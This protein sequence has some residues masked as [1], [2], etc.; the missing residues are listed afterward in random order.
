MPVTDHA[1]AVAF[2][3]TVAV[4]QAQRV[5]TIPGGFAVLNDQYRASYDHNKVILTEAIAPPAALAAVDR[6]LGDA[7][8][9]HRMVHVDDDAH[10][11]WYA[12]AFVAA[13]YSHEINIVMRHTGAAPDRPADQSVN[14]AQVDLDTLRAS[15]RREWR[16]RLPHATSEAI[17]Q[18]VGRRAA[19]LCGADEVTFLAVVDPAGRV[20]SR[21]DLYR[22]GA[23]AQIEDLMTDPVATGRG[24]ARAIMTEA[25]RRTRAA[26]C[27]LTFV[28]ADADDWPRHFYARLGYAAVSRTH[29]FVRA[30]PQY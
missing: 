12:A 13:G 24:Y 20:L 25:L 11:G 17:D 21:A 19:I 29:T 4:R 27:D 3:R 7:G 16:Q 1:T 22:T 30:A 23:V 10:G 9:T 14:V 5:V 2:L 8:H 28:V 18:L 26:G 6:V 15:S